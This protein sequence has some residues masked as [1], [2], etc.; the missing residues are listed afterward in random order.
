M[1]KDRN[2]E[3]FFTNYQAEGKKNENSNLNVDGDNYGNREDRK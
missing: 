1:K 2:Y 3:L